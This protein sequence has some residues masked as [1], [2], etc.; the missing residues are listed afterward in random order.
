MTR[1]YY[2]TRVAGQVR[3]LD[4]LTLPWVDVSNAH[5]DSFLDVM[6]VPDNPDAVIVV[7]RKRGIYS[8]IDA[9]TSWNAATGDYTTTFAD[10]YTEIW[11]VDATTSYIA[12]GVGGHVLKSTDG[13]STYNILTNHPTPGGG[14]DGDTESTALHFINAT[15]GVVTVSLGGQTSIWK[16]FDGG[17]SWSQ[18]NGGNVFGLAGARGVHISA[19][20]QNIVV[21]TSY[22]V[23]RS[24]DAGLTFTQTLDLTVDFVTGSGQHLTWIDDTTM[25]VTGNGD[26]VRQSTDGGATWSILQVYNSLLGAVLGAHF[27]DV[28]NGFLT[29]G[30]EIHSTADGGTTTVIS[31]ANVAPNAIWTNFETPPQ[32]DPCYVLTN[33]ADNTQQIFTGTDLENHVGTVITLS[34]ADGSELPECWFV[35]VNPAGCD[36]DTATNVVIYKCYDD[37]DSCLPKPEPIRTPKPRAVL[38]NYTTGN[39][40]PAIVEKAFCNHAEMI[41]RRVMARRFKLKNCC[42]KDDMAV[43]IEYL[44]IKHKLIEGKNLTPDPCNPL[45]MTFEGTIQPGYSATISY[46]DC[47][48]EEQIDTLE[49]TDTIQTI[50]VCAL[51]TN[52]PIVTLFDSESTEVESFTLFSEQDC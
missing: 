16:T 2:V 34:D 31:E 12:A 27:Y 48:G 20:E 25:W 42:H 40:D 28:N 33:C 49:L 37:C 9:G 52:P 11:I 50:S 18:L 43:E 22:G 3:R 36:P 5:T 44:K 15:T 30:Q 23:W 35:N 7:G 51:N 24:T 39:C 13:G 41:Y 45:C 46:T 47:D 17:S 10:E 19:D 21:L 14:A 32:V 6:T 29:Q 26:T 1:T 8:S 38:P 4:D